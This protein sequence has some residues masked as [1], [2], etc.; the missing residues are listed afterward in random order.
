MDT[1]EHPT[2]AM[3]VDH[4]PLVGHHV[5]SL[6]ARLPAH[7]SRNDLVSAGYLALVRAARAFDPTAGVPFVNYATYR[8]KGALVDELRRTDVVSRR[9]RRLGRVMDE[10][11]DRLAATL[12]RVP[13][14][15]GPR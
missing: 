10:V 11:S 4:M 3:V 2:N 13:R 14:R 9:A 12:G 5:N 6:F 1:P 15:G 8:I 7:V